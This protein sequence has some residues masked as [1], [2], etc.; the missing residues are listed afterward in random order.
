[1]PVLAAR[2]GSSAEMEVFMERNEYGCKNNKMVNCGNRNGCSSCGWDEDTR[3]RRLTE[4]RRQRAKIAGL[5]SC[6]FCGRQP[7][8]I[9]SRAGYS[10]RCRN[11]LCLLPAPGIYASLDA[12]AKVWN[13]RSFDASP[14]QIRGYVVNE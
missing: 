6:P 12:A 2:F 10:I 9:H 7:F 1:M 5:A 8:A 3:N 11:G 4:I 13:R 14:G